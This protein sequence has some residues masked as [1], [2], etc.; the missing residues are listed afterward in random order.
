VLDQIVRVLRSECSCRLGC[1]LGKL[2]SL[3]LNQQFKL[4]DI[5]IQCARPHTV[6]DQ[7]GPERSELATST[8][9]SQ[10]LRRTRVQ[11]NTLT[12]PPTLFLQ[13]VDRLHHCVH[14]CN[15]NFFVI[16]AYIHIL[17]TPRFT[18]Q[19]TPLITHSHHCIHTCNHRLLTLLI[20]THIVFSPKYIT[21][22]TPSWIT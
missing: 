5:R 22:P 1:N 14:T 21:L 4:H 12:L 11:T 15:H 6:A 10:T 13:I 7:P 17:Y 3:A 20:H 16:S 2:R 8:N 19:P 9:R 18:T